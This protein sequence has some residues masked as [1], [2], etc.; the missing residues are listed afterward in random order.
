MVLLRSACA[1]DGESSVF[2]HCTGNSGHRFLRCQCRC[3]TNLPKLA[4]MTI[5][6][7]RNART[8]TLM[9]GDAEAFARRTAEA[10][11]V[12]LVI[13]DA[14]GQARPVLVELQPADSSRRA[15]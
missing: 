2:S 3:L 7:K 15:A 14:A 9:D 4:N 12:E 13:V 10:D 1:P 6:D 8:V 11:V 5:M